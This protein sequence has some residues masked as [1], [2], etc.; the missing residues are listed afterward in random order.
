MKRLV[1]LLLV[2]L[3]AIAD[4][5]IIIIDAIIFMKRLIWNKWIIINWYKLM[6]SFYLKRDGEFN[7]SLRI[8]ILA[9]AVMSPRGVDKYLKNLEERRSQAH[10]LTL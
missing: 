4:L 1:Q 2:I 6:F 3:T 8:D 9:M 10:F 7:K 5:T